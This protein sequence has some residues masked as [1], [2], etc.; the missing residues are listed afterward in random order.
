MGTGRV[1]GVLALRRRHTVLLSTRARS[2]LFS[3]GNTKMN[4]E[5]IL[6]A[7]HCCAAFTPGA[8][9]A[10]KQAGDL[11]DSEGFSCPKFTVLG[12]GTVNREA[13]GSTCFECLNPFPPNDLDSQRVDF[14]SRQGA[15]T[16]TKVITFSSLS[17]GTRV[18]SNARINTP[19]PAQ[20]A[21]IE[22]TLS[23]A[24][25]NVRHGTGTQAMQAATGRAIRAA[26]MLKQA[27][28]EANTNEV[29]A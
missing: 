10:T 23:M 8:R 21:T 18:Q 17:T 15:K 29:A 2:Q 25:W 11:P 27:C 5:S 13:T 6:Q 19:T 20:Q 3:K 4:I 7:R 14:Q 12:L 28:T 24:L 16:M 1:S 22:N 9:H 26:S